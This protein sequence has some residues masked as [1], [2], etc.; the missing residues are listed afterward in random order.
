MNNKVLAG[1]WE[2]CKK[3]ARFSGVIIR[4]GH[5]IVGEGSKSPEHGSSGE[6]REWWGGIAEWPMAEGKQWRGVDRLLHCP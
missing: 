5:T 3:A 4:L 6:E 2:C 1:T